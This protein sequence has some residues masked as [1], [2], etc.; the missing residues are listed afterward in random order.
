LCESQVKEKDMKFIGETM[1]KVLELVKSYQLPKIKEERKEYFVKFKR[2]INK[3]KEI[4]A[5]RAKVKKMAVK[6][7]IP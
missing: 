5:F 7:P 1:I 4:K 6:F 2:E 3:N